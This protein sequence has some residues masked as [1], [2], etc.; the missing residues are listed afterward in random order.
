MGRRRSEAELTDGAAVAVYI[1]LS[2]DDDGALVEAASVAASR[3]R[4]VCFGTCSVAS[5]KYACG[6]GGREGGRV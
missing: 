6:E 4:D 1:A 2:R 5:Q 3:S